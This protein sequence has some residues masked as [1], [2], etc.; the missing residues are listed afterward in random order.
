[1]Y[2]QNRRPAIFIQNNTYLS[3]KIILDHGLIVIVVI[4]EVELL[5]LDAGYEV[6]YGRIRFKIILDFPH[7]PMFGYVIVTSR[8]RFQD[9]LTEKISIPET[10]KQ[11]SRL[12]FIFLRGF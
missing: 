4:H 10:E 1:M 5:H 11:K 6:G 7:G 9:N 8:S 3:I 2:Y 12:L